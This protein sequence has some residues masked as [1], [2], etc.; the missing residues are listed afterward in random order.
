MYKVSQFTVIELIDDHKMLVYN[1]LTQSYFVID[2]DYLMSWT[3]EVDVDLLLKGKFLVDEKLDEKSYLL[4]RFKEINNSNQVLDIVLTITTQCE[5][6]CKYCYEEGISMQEISA[7]VLTDTLQWINQYIEKYNIMTL[8]VL[9]FGG[10]P[11]YNIEY[12]ETVVNKI[13]NSV[14]IP[15]TF[16]LASNG[17]N[18]QRKY[19]E[20]LIEKGLVSIQIPLD[21]PQQIHD[22]RRP[23]KNNNSTKKNFEVILDNIRDIV[24]LPIEICIKINI[25]KQNCEYVGE[26]LDILSETGMREKIILKF[27]SIALTLS[28]RENQNHFCNAFAF[29][30]RSPEMSIAYH[31]CME[32][33]RK[34][35]FIVSP[36]IGN[37][38]PC[39]YS[40]V[41][42]Y[43]IDCNGFLYKC[44]SAVGI[45]AFQVG[46]VKTS[47]LT[48]Y[49]YR[50][51]IKRMHIA[52]KCL[53][54]GCPYVPK[55]GGGCAYEA[56]LKDGDKI[57]I[58]CKKA[59]FKDYFK[60]KFLL[61][62]RRGN[63]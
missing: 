56:Y 21:G 27:E 43:A 8:H 45:P 6:K 41:H 16:S 33:A 50:C 57:D 61:E 47:E 13:T 31:D 12:L 59:Y 7:D 30:S 2:S 11:L 37:I 52:E 53:V 3:E 63:Q 4:D 40:A 34:K 10:E 38:T 22:L 35:G 14:I 9:L 25:D 28:S 24:D 18:M 42:K 44:I 60:R 54:A 1:M 55:C 19:V 46:S 26:L 23:L 51:A 62:Y 48:S 20:W 32:M 39:M 17:Y 49:A 36:T 15:V 5:M 58:D 29:E